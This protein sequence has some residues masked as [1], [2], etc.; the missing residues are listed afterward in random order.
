MLISDADDVFCLKKQKEKMIRNYGMLRGRQAL[1]TTIM[2][3]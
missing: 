2:I 3:L 1:I